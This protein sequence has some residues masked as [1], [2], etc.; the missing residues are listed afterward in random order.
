MKHRIIFLALIFGAVFFAIPVLADDECPAWKDQTFRKLHSAETFNLCES[1][2]NQPMLIVNTASHCGFTP[3]FSALEAVYQ[4]FR[5][6]G[7]TVVGFASDDFRQAAENEEIAA[8]ICYKNFGV[9][10]TMAAPISV[11]GENASPLFQQLAAKTQA[12]DWNF[13]KYLVSADGER[14]EY[15]SSGELPNS[16]EMIEKISALLVR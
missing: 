11:K 6:E 16:P 8:E 10:F 14:V 13:N 9:T 3:Q 5:N 12:P 7:F 2:P 15:F 4:R 1:F